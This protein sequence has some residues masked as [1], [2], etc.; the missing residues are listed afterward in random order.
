MQGDTITRL[1]PDAGEKVD[2]L[3]R[4]EAASDWGKQTEVYRPS[5]SVTAKS[6][7]LSLCGGHLYGVYVL[8]DK[9]DRD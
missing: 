9:S 4:A 6:M 3:R 2:S 8:V 1:V 5:A 7:E